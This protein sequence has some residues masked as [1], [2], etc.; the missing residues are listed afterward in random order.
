MTHETWRAVRF[1]G[2]VEN[3]GAYLVAWVHVYSF[4]KAMELSSVFDVVLGDGI[5][6]VAI[7][8]N[9]TMSLGLADSAEQ[10]RAEELTHL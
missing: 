4:A 10:S 3:A 1:V 9:P 7:A 2:T 5:L 8:V 6:N